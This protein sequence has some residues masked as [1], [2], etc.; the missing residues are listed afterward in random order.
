M[1]QPVRMDLPK[2]G[3]ARGRRDNEGCA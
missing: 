2:P 3:S 1:P